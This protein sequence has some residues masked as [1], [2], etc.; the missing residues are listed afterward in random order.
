MQQDVRLCNADASVYGHE[1]TAKYT[2]IAACGSIIVQT[3]IREAFRLASLVQAQ[4]FSEYMMVRALELGMA[5]TAADLIKKTVEGSH[6]CS[7]QCAQRRCK[8][9]KLG[10][11]GLSVYDSSL[12]QLAGLNPEPPQRTYENDRPQLFTLNSMHKNGTGRT[13][14]QLARQMDYMVNLF[15]AL[16]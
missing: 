1:N 10:Q 8:H 15:N 6:S 11:Q 12:L 14:I 13:K 3:M 4:V 5:V 9:H 2:I 16:A 7:S